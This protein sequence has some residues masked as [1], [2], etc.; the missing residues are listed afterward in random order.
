VFGLKNLGNTCFFNSTI[1]CL[2]AT[3][4]LHALYGGLALDTEMEF[5]KVGEITLLFRKF[6]KNTEKHLN[7]KGIFSWVC[8]SKGVYKNMDQQDAQELLGVLLNGLIDGEKFWMGEEKAKALA[9]GKKHTISEKIFG[10]YLA[11]RLECLDC[12]KVSWSIDFSLEVAVSLTKAFNKKIALP[13]GEV[14]RA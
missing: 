7:P 8:R 6:L 11:S 3:E 12:E 4:A 1:Q 10:F 2:Y 14:P 9:K 13:E 5:G